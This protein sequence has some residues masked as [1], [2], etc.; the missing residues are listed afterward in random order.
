MPLL[1]K[2]NDPP[3]MIEGRIEQR[4]KSPDTE[5]RQPSFDSGS[6]TNEADDLGQ[7]ACLTRPWFP[8]L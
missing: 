2:P 3:P 1:T 6:A 4:A 7:V 5:N 8:H